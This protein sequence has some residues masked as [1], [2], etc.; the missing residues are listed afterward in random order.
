MR[1]ERKTIPE[2]LI[3]RIFTQICLGLQEI[4]RT[5]IIHRDI[6]LRNVLVFQRGIVKIGDFGISKLLDNEDLYATTG[7]GTPYYMAPELCFGKNYSFKADIWGLGCLLFEM[8]A[9]KRP[10]EGKF[11]NVY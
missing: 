11:I 3:L 5:K 9:G 10:F 7:I 1:K 6:K 4:H 8:A 2:E